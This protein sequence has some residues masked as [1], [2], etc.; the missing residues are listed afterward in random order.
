MQVKACEECG[1]ENIQHDV[2]KLVTGQVKGH[3]A[4]VVVA[5][6]VDCGWKWRVE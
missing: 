3:E 2:M 1:C 6:C 4:E 5:S